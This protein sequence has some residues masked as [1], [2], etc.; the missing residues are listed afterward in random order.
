ML[1][2]DRS[3]VYSDVGALADLMH[4]A[5]RAPDATAAQRTADALLAVVRGPLLPDSSAP[6]AV[7]ARE[8]CRRRF[9]LAV[10]RLAQ[11]LEAASPEAAARLFERA[12][13]VDPLA[14]S[15]HRR[16]MRLQAQ[17]GARAEAL[18]AY[19]HCRAMLQ[20]DGGL[21]PDAE[22]QAL[23]RELGLV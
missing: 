5:E 7:A 17:R 15:L 9:V 18:R 8:R 6:W 11:V 2:L 22:T 12:L 13:D 1:V 3:L 10:S 21:E 16:L 14:E 4:R 19:R 23:A 20:L